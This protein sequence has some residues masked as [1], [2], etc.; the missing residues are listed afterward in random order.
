MKTAL[1]IYLSQ[2][3][4]ATLS[5][6]EEFALIE[7]YQKK[8]EG[9]EEAQDK[10]IRGNLLFIVRCAFEMSTDHHKVCDLISE[11]NISLLESLDKFDLSRGCR[12]L[13]YASYDIRGRMLKH[14]AKNNYFSALKVSLKNVELANKAK[15]FIE[16]Y[17]QDNNVD[18]SASEIAAHCGIEFEKALMISEL[19]QFK[20][21]SVQISIDF[22]DDEKVSEIKDENGL[23]PDEEANSS[24]MSSIIAKIISDLPLKQQIVINKR[25]GL[26]GETRTDLAT[27]GSQL[28]LTKERIR[29]IEGNVL[30]II[31][32]EL[33]KLNG[34]C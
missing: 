6:E 12:F 26:N 22:D 1:D 8:Q 18:P 13:T 25:F 16:S 5:Q 21:Q 19:A 27:I 33:E 30:K 3:K 32:K 29:Q 15:L 11:G 9:W 23:R 34:A 14:L 2:L 10:I 4:N 24:D 20:I 7:V 31:R 17:R 28:D